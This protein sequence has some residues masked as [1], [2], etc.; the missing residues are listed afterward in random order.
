MGGFRR[1]IT[2]DKTLMAVCALAAIVAIAQPNIKARGALQTTEIP[3]QEVEKV[4]I[5]LAASTT[6]GGEGENEQEDALIDAALVGSRYFSDAIPLPFELQDVVQTACSVYDIP[7]T[8]ALGVIETESNFDVNAVNSDVGC[9]GLFQLNPN[10]FP[11]GLSPTD[12]IYAGMGYLRYQL[13]RYNEDIPAALTAYNAGN[14]MGSRVY[15]DK[16]L[17]SADK[18]AGVLEEG[19]K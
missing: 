17:A 4:S 10:Y 8:L 15:A 18:W 14:D 6:A 12:N 7:Y 11:R 2:T 9:Y 5:E 3:V 16:V 19:L 13:D 1:L